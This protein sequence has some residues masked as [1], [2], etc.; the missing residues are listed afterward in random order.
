MG[1]DIKGKEIGEGFSQ[2]KDGRYYA[3]Y[4]DRFGKRVTLYNRDLDALKDELNTAIYKDKTQSNVVDTSLT[5]DQ[6]FDK[7][8]NIYKFGTIRSST[9]RIYKHVYYKHISTV[10]GQKKLNKI[11]H[12]EVVGLIKELAKRNYKY[13][14][15]NKVRIIL[16]DMFNK[17]MIDE[18]VSKNPAQGI[19]L[20]K[21][22]CEINVLSLE[23][24]KEFFECA[25]GTFYSNLFQVAILTGLRQGELCAL[26]WNDIDLENKYINVDKT[27]LYQKLDGDKGK[28]FHIQE[29]KTKTSKRR[30]PINKDCEIALLKQKRQYEII[31]LKRCYKPIDGFEDLLFTTKYGTPINAQIYGDAIKKII[32]EI[33]LTREDC[34]S[35]ENFSSH[36]FRHTFATRCFENNI[37]PKVVQ[38]YLGHATLSMTMDLYTHVLEEV[39]QEEIHKLTILDGVNRGAEIKF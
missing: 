34:D 15:Q 3:R 5:L 29:P 25:L 8:I 12:L 38:K 22:K 18:L 17:A 1:K 33:N 27:L 24:Q 26:T 32:D 19:K 20:Q 28:T 11:K 13:E 14:T 30:V 23:D 2:R 10:L 39:Q 36:T 31:K 4:T 6:W 21:D 35:L 9:I 16:L 7:W 37:N